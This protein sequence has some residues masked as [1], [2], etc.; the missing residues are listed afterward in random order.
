LNFI[1]DLNAVAGTLYVHGLY[2]D[3]NPAALPPGYTIHQL[4]TSPGY[5]G[6][7]TYSM[8]TTP[9]GLPLLEPLR[10]MPILGNPLADLLQPDLTTIV[11]LGYGSPDQ[12]WSLGYADVPTPFR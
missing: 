10:A 7:T 1:S 4:S 3:L 9:R 8:M 12:G 5:H 6:V 11:N 2:P